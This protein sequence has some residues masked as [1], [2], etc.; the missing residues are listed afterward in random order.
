MVDE[1]WEITCYIHD[2][3]VQIK[4]LQHYPRKSGWCH[5]FCRRRRRHPDHLCARLRH[6]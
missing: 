1:P 4:L 3:T 5:Y 2:A 6:H